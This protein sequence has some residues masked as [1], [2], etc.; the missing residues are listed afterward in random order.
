MPNLQ[1]L[2]A[3]KVPHFG[4]RTAKYRQK[5]CTLPQITPL[6]AAMTWPQHW[7]TSNCHVPGTVL[8]GG[9]W[10]LMPT[11]QVLALHFQR[12]SLPVRRVVSLQPRQSVPR[13]DAWSYCTPPPFYQHG[14]FFPANMYAPMHLF[15]FSS[16][17]LLS[18]KYFCLLRPYFII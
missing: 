3:M 6:L 11:R 15:F 18:L 16:W 5:D 1:G 14:Y 13:E 7:R 8:H 12:S 9:R 4:L 17:S 10:S 2:H